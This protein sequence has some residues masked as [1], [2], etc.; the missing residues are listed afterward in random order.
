MANINLAPNEY[1]I[2]QSTAVR[3]GSAWA[4][5][6]D[7]LILTNL[8]VILVKKGVFGN[9]K[10]EQRFPIDQIKRVNETPQVMLGKNSLNGIEQ[11]QITFVHGLEWFEFQSGGKKEILKWIETIDKLIR[12]GSDN[13]SVYEEDRMSSINSAIKKGIDSVRNGLGVN[14]GINTE[15][16]SSTTQNVRCSGCMAPL[17]GKPGEVV[18]CIYCDT[19]HIF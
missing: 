15:S 19:K 4:V 12:C 13:I 6:T 5:Y 3:S 11:L 18:K 16:T 9:I 14:S 2:L 7:E 1:I 17:S 10:G 8:N